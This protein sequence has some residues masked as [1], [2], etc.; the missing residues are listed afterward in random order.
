MCVHNIQ[1]FPEDLHEHTKPTMLAEDYKEEQTW[2]QSQKVEKLVLCDGEMKH[3]ERDE[4][5]Q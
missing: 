4:D 1:N 2:N 3:E 5:S